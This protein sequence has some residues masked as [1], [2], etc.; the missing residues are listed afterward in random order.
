MLSDVLYYEIMMNDERWMKRVLRLARQGEGKTSPNPMVGAIVVKDGLVVGKGYHR[1][2]GEPHAEILALEQA[3]ASA[4]EATLYVNLEPCTHYGRTPPCAP[5]VIE[6]GVRR[7]VIGMKDP[8][9]LVAGRGVS[10]L[11]EAGLEVKVGV[12]E[13]ECRSLNEAFCKYIVRKEPFIILKAAMTLDGRI[14]TRDGDSK[15][16]SNESSRKWVHRLRSA[17]DGIVVGI[18]TVLRD[19]PLLTARVKGGRDPLR[20]VLDSRLRIPE[21]ARVIGDEPS[22]LIVA[23]TE[24][25]SAAARQE[26]E[27]RGVRV[28]VF[29]SRQGRVNL[30]SFASAMGAMEITSLLVEGGSEVNGAF[31]DEGLVDK[32]ILFIAPKLIG[33]REALSVFGGR[34]VSKLR[35]AIVVKGLKVRR[36]GDDLLVEGYPVAS[37]RDDGLCKQGV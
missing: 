22:R 7:V 3:G 16:I 21:N 15:W 8:N 28:M 5:R 33:D 30:R 34:G 12:L 20:I 2:A 35:D 25:S 17:V 14:G 23:T 36:L 4:R 10:A 32:L 13:E 29:D 31:L 24:A 6:A 11:S 27:R 37:V 26:L 1:K 9:P 19:D 18:G